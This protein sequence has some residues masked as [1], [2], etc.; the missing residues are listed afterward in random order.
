MKHAIMVLALMG[1][2]ASPRPA[3]AAASGNNFLEM[4]NAS[5]LACHMYVKGWLDAFTTREFLNKICVPEG[6]NLAADNRGASQ[7]SPCSPRNRW[8]HVQRLMW[9]DVIVLFQPSIYDDL[10]LLD[11]R[12][13]FGI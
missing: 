12:E 11:R 5:E 8:S 3:A 6:G 10:S 7:T 4:C 1:V 9:A 13:P 2:L